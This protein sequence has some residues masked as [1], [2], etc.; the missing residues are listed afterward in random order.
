MEE[1]LEGGKEGRRQGRRGWREGRK[2]EER[3]GELMVK[4][5]S[6]AVLYS[7]CENRAG[8][9]RASPSVICGLQ[10]VLG[11]NMEKVVQSG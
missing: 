10:S 5:C 6:A 2:G 8:V 1:R 9:F 3:A 4:A 7:E 11:Q